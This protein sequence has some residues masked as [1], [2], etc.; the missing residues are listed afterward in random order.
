MLPCYTGTARLSANIIQDQVQRFQQSEWKTL[1]ALRELKTLMVEFKNALLGRHLDRLGELLHFDWECKRR[2]SGKISNPQLGALYAAAQEAGA[3]GGK[4][5][6]AGGGFMM[7]YCRFSKRHKVAEKLKEMGCT[8]TDISFEP[9]GLQTWRA[10]A[11][12]C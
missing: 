4:I 7:V 5:T 12:A 6:G 11:A 10:R 8:L 9:L 1:Q 2:L 3:V